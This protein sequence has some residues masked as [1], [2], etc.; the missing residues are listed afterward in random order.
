[1]EQGL[2]RYNIDRSKCRI[3]H[4][5]Y[6]FVLHVSNGNNMIYLYFNNTS[7]LIDKILL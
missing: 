4:G 7:Y 2:F 5:K 1:M 6:M 3:I